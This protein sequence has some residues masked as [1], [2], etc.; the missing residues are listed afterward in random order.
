MVGR[1]T[2]KPKQ[3]KTEENATG[4]VIFRGSENL[5][6]T[7]SVIAALVALLTAWVVLSTLPGEGTGAVGGPLLIG[8]GLIAVLLLGV[9]FART[10]RREVVV[11]GDGLALRTREGQEKFRLVWTQV[12]RIETRTLPSNPT[13]PAIVIHCADGTA[14]FI[15]PVQVHDT[16]ALLGEVQ[17]RKKNADDAARAATPES[18]RPT[19]AARDHRGG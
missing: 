16:R 1:F 18:L 5:W 10:Q 9:W 6:I 13:R 7:L 19:S 17:R 3:G 2:A 15:D 8:G 11:D 4:E 12:S 14:H